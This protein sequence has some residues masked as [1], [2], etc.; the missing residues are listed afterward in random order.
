[1]RTL[2]SFT[3][4]TSIITFA[5]LAPLAAC[6]S[7]P[8]I[9]PAPPQPPPAQSPQTP[10]TAAAP[11]PAVKPPRADAKLIPRDV[12]FGNPERAAPRISPD[13]KQIAFLAPDQGVLNVWVAPADKPADA[14]VVTKD[15]KRGVRVFFW[16]Y[17]GQHLLYL[18]DKDG[19]ENF[20]LYAANLKSG[21]TKDLTAV[22]GV[23]AQVVS[24]SDK[25]PGEVLVGLN[26]RDKKYHDLHRVNLKT[27]ERK[28]VYKNERFAEVVADDD[29]KPRLGMQMTADGGTELFDLSGKEPKSFVKVAQEDS[30]T[31]SP[32]GYD[33]SGKI[34]YFTDSR[35]R[36]TAALVTLNAQGKPTVL[37]EDPKADMEQG[38]FHPK[39]GKVQAGISAYD[40]RGWHVVDKAIQPDLDYL[41]TVADG[42]FDIISRS[43]D[44]KKWTVGYMLSNGPVR[45]YLYDRA[46]KKAE[47]LFTNNKKLESLELSKMHP[48]II[49]SRDGLDLVSYLS[50][51]PSADKD[52][53]GRPAQPLPMVLLVHGGP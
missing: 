33:A 44:D 22:D 50:L 2:R 12:L 26:D 49:K 8:P 4:F 28:L 16:P 36:D 6:S 23:R 45:Y 38:V 29:F 13:G 31:T 39:T 24:V 47:F 34:L 53:D 27:G 46:K 9:E 51:P 5:L 19:D 17:D 14:K 42:D 52:G 21:E 48:V 41:K 43:L 37:A 7:A 32:I 11:A 25:I 35:G 20:H 10:G 15:R 18:Q 40:R 30:L 1:M 3:R